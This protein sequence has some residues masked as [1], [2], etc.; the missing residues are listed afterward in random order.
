MYLHKV[1]LSYGTSKID[2]IAQS[3]T[4]CFNCGPLRIL[5]MKN[6]YISNLHFKTIGHGFGTYHN[7]YT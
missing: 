1:I 4:Y 6:Q 3:M 7:P 5:P 2:T